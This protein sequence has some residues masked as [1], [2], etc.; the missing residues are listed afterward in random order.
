MTFL[1]PV[2]LLASQEDLE[3]AQSLSPDDKTVTKKLATLAK[4]AKLYE[5]KEKKLWA[6][7]FPRSAGEAATSTMTGAEAS[8]GAECR[9]ATMSTEA[10]ATIGSATASSVSDNSQSVG[11]G[12]TA[13]SAGKYQW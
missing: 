6:G 3:K 5:Q 2:L 11:N 4:K 10:S 13:Q 12:D 7:A 1:L 9:T 8:G